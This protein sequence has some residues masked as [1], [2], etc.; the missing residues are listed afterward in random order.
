M[1]S[2]RALKDSCYPS[3][4]WHY[5][6]PI[7]CNIVHEIDMVD[8]MTQGS[9]TLN[10]EG[11][12]QGT[13]KT[14]LLFS[15]SQREAWMTASHSNGAL[16]SYDLDNAL[17]NKPVILKMFRFAK[18]YTK[19]KF[20]LNRLDALASERTSASPYVVNSFGFCGM[21]V[22][23]EFANG[24]DLYHHL[25]SSNTTMTPI[26]KLMVCRDSALG[27]AD[28]HGIDGPKHVPTLMHRDIRP[29][30]F[31]LIDG[32][33]KYHDFNNAQVLTRNIKTGEYC[34]YRRTIPCGE[35]ESETYARSP[36]ECSKTPVQISE[37]ADVYEL[38]VFFFRLVANDNPYTFEPE[39][40]GRP[41]SEVRDWIL[42]ENRIPALPE[43]VEKTNDPAILA[44]IEMARKA[45]THDRFMRPSARELS[46][47]LVQ[48]TN[49]ILEKLS[50]L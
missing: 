8:G 5:Y 16:S 28:I 15:G 11:K 41:L 9:S 1:V 6:N 32:Q 48:I 3:Q 36:E 14:K 46:T 7:T 17:E 45:M 40:K 24:G 38:G 21:T 42:D 43:A 47:D 33:L 50:N 31:L 22:L 10:S 19:K 13:I 39:G 44:I 23:N 12:K 18:D 27:L 29:H 30:N 4:E 20:D 49:E 25:Q 37:K 34:D 26:Q 35:V 2:K